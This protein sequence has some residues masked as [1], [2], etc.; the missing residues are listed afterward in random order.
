[1]QTAAPPG[2]FC[3]IITLGDIQGASWFIL[4][5]TYVDKIKDYEKD[6]AF[7]NYGTA[8]NANRVIVRRREETTRQ[9]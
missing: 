9:T 1:V 7:D 3:Y 8:R 4:L 2:A 5:T 6:G